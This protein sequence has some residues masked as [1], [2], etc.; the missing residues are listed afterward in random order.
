MFVNILFTSLS[1]DYKPRPPGFSNS[2][3]CF[4][5]NRKSEIN[6]YLSGSLFAF[7]TL[8]N[9]WDDKPVRCMCWYESSDSFDADIFKNRKTT[10]WRL[11][12]L[13]EWSI[14]STSRI[15]QLSTQIAHAYLWKTQTGYHS[16]TLKARFKSP[17]VET[18]TD[19]STLTCSDS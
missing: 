10:E 4:Q 5:N 18:V 8:R 7:I 1:I 11:I 2:S 17:N 13:R 19:C 6:H 14:R 9:L 16:F 12:W 15:L 3:C